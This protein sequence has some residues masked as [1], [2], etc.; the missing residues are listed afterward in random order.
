MVCIRYRKSV[1]K[2]LV[3]QSGRVGV[4]QGKVAKND[5]YN[6]TR[7]N[8]PTFKSSFD[9]NKTWI[10]NA[11]SVDMKAMY[12]D[13]LPESIPAKAAWTIPKLNEDELAA[14]KRLKSKHG[15][16]AH[17]MAKDRKSNPY[18]WSAEQ[19]ERKMKLMSQARIHVCS[20]KCL[21]GTTK[22]SSY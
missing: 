15:E 11:A 18:Q 12:E 14:I 21:C 6:P 19:C 1:R 16:D 5:F 9:K 17:A 8:D 3:K 20:D 2:A 13:K 10:E 7:I 4:Y 22:S